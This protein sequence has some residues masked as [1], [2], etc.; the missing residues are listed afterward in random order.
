MTAPAQATAAAL[1]AWH[2]PGRPLILPN[3]WDAAGARLVAEAGFPAVATSSDA[4][5]QSLGFADHEQAP[6]DEMLA[7]ATRIAN[8]VKVPVTVDAEAGYGLESAELADRLLTAGAV[9]CNIEDTDHAI[10]QPRAAGV[11][12]EYLAG[13]RAAA[14][15]SLVINAR[16]DVFLKSDEESAVLPDAV[17]RAKRYLEAGADCVYPIF[18]RTPALIHT[19]VEE[20]SPAAVNI[21]ALP[22]GPGV[23]GLADLNVAR[24]SFATGLFRAQQALLRGKL[25]E[26]VAD[27]ARY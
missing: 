27:S 2:V 19:F 10:G 6:A 4:V 25:Q 17:D 20:L 22:D 24:V 7:A 15:D 1:R 26:I 14:G 11:H 13:I 8:A 16:V 5:A 12:A 9:G 3:I 23:A 18:L 21:I